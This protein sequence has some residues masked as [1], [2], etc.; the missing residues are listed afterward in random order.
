[1]AEITQA[2]LDAQ[3]ELILNTVKRG[4]DEQGAQIVGL[5]HDV[6]AF[7][8]DTSDRFARI[9]ASLARLTESV[10]HFIKIYSDLTQEMTVLRQHVRD[11]EER[12]GKV[13]L[14]LKAA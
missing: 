9:E 5:K 13:E 12:L 8:A 14:K 10:D 1:M 4:F 6:Q 11:M 7:K 3:T 2:N